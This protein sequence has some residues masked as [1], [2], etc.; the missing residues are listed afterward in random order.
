MEL[1]EAEL[2]RAMRYK[3]PYGV[4]LIDV[5]YFKTVNDKYGHKAGD[6]VLQALGE[7]LLS[8]LREV[9]IIGRI[10]GEEFAVLLPQTDTATA[11]GVAERLRQ[12]VADTEIA[13]GNDRPLHITISIGLAMPSEQTNHIDII[14]R[15]ADKALYAAKNSGRNRVCVAEAA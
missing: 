13:I 10:G 3:S 6:A 7:I 11:E 14:L 4:L 8:S 1:A 9:D 15:Q 2:A 5:D 12:T